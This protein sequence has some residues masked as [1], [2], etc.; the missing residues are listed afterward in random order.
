MVKSSKAVLSVRLTRVPRL[1]SALRVD[2]EVLGKFKSQFEPVSVG[3]CYPGRDFEAFPR[4]QKTVSGRLI[5]N[6]KLMKFKKLI[7]EDR[8]IY[9]V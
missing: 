2:L 8:F 9:I 5:V 6:A 4:N 7:K 1:R 3:Q